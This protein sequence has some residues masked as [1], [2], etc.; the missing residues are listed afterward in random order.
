MQN[1]FEHFYPNL[2]FNADFHKFNAE[3]LFTPA[4]LELCKY[5]SIVLSALVYVDN[6]KGLV[7]EEY[8]VIILGSF[9]LISQNKTK[10]K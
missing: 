6:C 2:N 9:L 10:K 3:I 1:F 4:Y 7:K 5:G 8:F